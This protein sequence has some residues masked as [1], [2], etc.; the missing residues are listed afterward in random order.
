MT[1]TKTLACLCVLFP[2]AACGGGSSP[3]V[4][5]TPTPIVSTP[6]PTP[7]PVA[8]ACNPT[9]PPLRYVRVKIAQ[10]I[11]YRKQLDS[12]PQVENVDNY[13][14]RVGLSGNFC[15]T[16][17]EGHPER[18]A[19]DFMAMGK[20]RDTGRYGPTWYYEDKLCAAGPD[21][22]GC[23]NHESN[24]FLVIAK[25]PGRYEACAAEDVPMA[26]DGERCGVCQIKGDSTAECN[27]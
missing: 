7:T 24:Q 2:L 14:Q 21:T 22:P 4:T 27:K 5:P 9:P 18:E 10:N 20:A 13:C 1:S 12:K 11:G 19:C 6:T 17:P 8:L 26:A 3:T 15:D 23:T 16:R 25:G